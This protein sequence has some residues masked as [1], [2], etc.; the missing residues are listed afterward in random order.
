MTTRKTTA[1]KKVSTPP[2]TLPPKSQ[3]RRT[4]GVTA[5]RARSRKASLR[6]FDPAKYAAPGAALLT[7]GLLAAAGY[8]LR[9]QL[10]GMLTQGARAA[11]RTAKLIHA[12]R[13]EAID[14]AEKL[15]LDSVLHL[16]GLQRTSTWTWVAGPAVGAMC[17]FVAGAGVGTLFGRK[18]LEQLKA[19]TTS[20]AT[21]QTEPETPE[22]P[23]SV[24]SATEGSHV[25]GGAQRDSY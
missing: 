13:D 10:G 1:S 7:T 17:G 23:R 9:S 4:S 16:A 18:L 21:A 24:P 11:G 20:H 8:A 6:E 5:G 12:V 25:N 3:K 14:T 19:V 22:S 2:I 15:S